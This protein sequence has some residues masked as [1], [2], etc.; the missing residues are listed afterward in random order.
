MDS[1]PQSIVV[2]VKN[3]AFFF[4]FGLL[5]KKYIPY[6]CCGHIDDVRL[7][8]VAQLDVPVGQV[9][10]PG[11]L[12]TR[13]LLT[14]ALKFKNIG[15]T[16][17]CPNFGYYALTSLFTKYKFLQM[18]ISFVTIVNRLSV[19]KLFQLSNGDLLFS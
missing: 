9:M 6:L 8:G 5:P 19:L 2:N 17:G 7:G 1:N 3:L 14:K 12:P 11:Q 16:V 15:I 18:K 4:F 13:K 10:Q